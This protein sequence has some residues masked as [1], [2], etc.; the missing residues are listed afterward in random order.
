MRVPI[1]KIGEMQRKDIENDRLHGGIVCYDNYSRICTVNTGSRRDIGDMS[2]YRMA[3]MFG[4]VW[5]DYNNHF[6]IQVAGC[7]LSCSYCYVDNL[8]PDIEFSAISIVALFKAVSYE[9]L[10][11]WKES[12]R[13]LHFM[14]GAPGVYCDFWPELREEMDSQGLENVVLFSNVIFVETRFAGVEPWLHMDLPR[15]IVEGC[16]KGT[17]RENFKRNT[18]KDLFAQ[19]KLE[20][21]QYLPYENFYLTLLNHDEADLSWVYS[22]INPSK[23][24][25]LEVVEYEATKVKRGAML[26]G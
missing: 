26:N 19:A 25:L 8:E 5:Q 10:S 15:F 22:Q 11:I 4:G 14:G 2:P 6:V 13:V 23:V 12:I 17:N 3:G 9:V 16:L 20:L 1:S 24:D 7:P 21:K 18:G